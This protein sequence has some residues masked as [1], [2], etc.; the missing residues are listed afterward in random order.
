VDIEQ[1]DT[2]WSVGQRKK[3]PLRNESGDEAFKIVETDDDGVDDEFDT[4]TESF[5]MNVE[6][7]GST[8]EDFGVLAVE[9]GIGVP[10]DP[11]GDPEALGGSWRLEFNTTK[12]TNQMVI[13]DTSNIETSATNSNYDWEANAP[14]NFTLTMYPRKGQANLPVD[15]SHLADGSS[16]ELDEFGDSQSLFLYGDMDIKSDYEIRFDGGSIEDTSEILGPCNSPPCVAMNPNGYNSEMH[17][18]AVV[19]NGSFK[20]RYYDGDAEYASEVEN[21]STSQDELPLGRVDG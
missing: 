21:I 7:E 4:N 16:L 2:V 12:S 19:D 1:E 6:V 20:Y 15:G 14:L 9:P 18:V 5:R 17:V 10:A 11:P 3:A 8:L 13:N